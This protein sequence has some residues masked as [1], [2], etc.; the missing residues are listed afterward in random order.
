MSIERGS[1][2]TSF[3]FRSSRALRNCGTSIAVEVTAVASEK[4]AVVTS[5][6]TS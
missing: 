1:A 3:W 5:E 6:S 4:F 2:G